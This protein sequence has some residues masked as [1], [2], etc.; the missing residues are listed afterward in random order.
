MEGTWIEIAAIIVGFV[1]RLALPLLLTLLLA[2]LLRRLD[3]RW[4]REAE[5][6][7]AARAERSPALEARGDGP[8]AAGLPAAA[9]PMAGQP[10]CWQIRRCP[11]EQR[12]TCPAYSRPDA[13]CWEVFQPNGRP[14][15]KCLKCT[16][17]QQLHAGPNGE[18][19]L[20]LDLK[21]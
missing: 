2:W 3:A 5:A 14:A 8:A 21:V 16:V 18:A 17:W 1:I 13:Y 7:A 19:D 4:Q 12:Q 9:G 10:K 20:A 15:E 11:P 6:E